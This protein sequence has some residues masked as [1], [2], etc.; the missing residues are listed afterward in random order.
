MRPRLNLALTEAILDA[1]RACYFDF[2][3]ALRKNTTEQPLDTTNDIMM[4]TAEW[5]RNV[6]LYHLMYRRLRRLCTHA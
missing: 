3:R 5:S 2:C 1:K 6:M 4:P